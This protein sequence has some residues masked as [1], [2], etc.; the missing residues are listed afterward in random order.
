MSLKQ[1][2]AIIRETR[3]KSVMNKL[4]HAGVSGAT[5]STARGFG[6][7]VNNYTSDGMEPYTRL[8]LI[9]DA[10]R[11]KLVAEL[12]M[13]VAHTGATGD[14]I[15]SI[16]TVDELYRIRDKKQLG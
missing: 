2:T 14:G 7:Y 15:V 10:E 13:E 11:A 9:L 5:V 4:R 1:V 16:T 8:E 3:V 6:E 12:I